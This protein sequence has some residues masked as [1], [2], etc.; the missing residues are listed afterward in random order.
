[1]KK[2]SSNFFSKIIF[3]FKKAPL[4][5]IFVI[6]NFLLSLLIYYCS[7]G[8]SIMTLIVSLICFIPFFTS[9]IFLKK[10]L[11]CKGLMSK[12]FYN[13][14]TLLLVI[15]FV[16]FHFTI[17]FICGFFSAL[18]DYPIRDF[19]DYWKVYRVFDDSVIGEF[20]PKKQSDKVKFNRFYYQEGFLQ[21][22]TVFLL[23]IQT[24]GEM[25]KDYQERLESISIQVDVD[26]LRL[27]QN[28]S[29]DGSYNLESYK[30]YYLEARCDD[31]GYCNHGRDVHIAIREMSNEMTFYYSY[32]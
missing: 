11:C 4:Q 25:I 20:L 6:F 1:M 16:M 12:I 7:I 2:K 5:L 14:V 17:L 30:T 10:Y 29:E 19:S 8:K 22:G 31:S 9:F 18:N 23:E 21:G 13:I 28:S 15:P 27:L 3:L 26:T 24:D 32:W